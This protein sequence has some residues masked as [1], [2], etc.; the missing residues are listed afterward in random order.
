PLLERG[1]LEVL[2]RIAAPLP[3]RPQRAG[4]RAVC[5]G[6]SESRAAG[7]RSAGDAERD[8]GPARTGASRGGD[9]CHRSVGVVPLEGPG[10]LPAMVWVRA[11]G[12]AAPGGS[13][14][15]PD[16]VVRRGPRGG[17]ARRQSRL[18]SDLVPA[19]PEA[20][21]WAARRRS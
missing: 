15:R 3:R 1:R 7:R 9:R 13:R 5:T 17:P 6:S 14:L 20:A 11:P 16:G 2:V 4:R 8:L 21:G 10:G 18:L 19:G 12:A